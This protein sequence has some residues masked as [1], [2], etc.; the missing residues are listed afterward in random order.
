LTPDGIVQTLQ[1]SYGVPQEAGVEMLQ[2]IDL[3]GNI[4]AANFIALITKKR[5][6]G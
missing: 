4:T 2:E 5:K 3:M 6:E 1:T